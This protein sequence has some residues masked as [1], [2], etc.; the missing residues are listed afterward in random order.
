[1]VGVPYRQQ[2]IASQFDGIVIGSGIGGLSAAVLLARHGGK[3]LLVLARHYTA[4][5]F[6]P[7]FRRP[8]FEWDVGVH[9]IG[10]V[11]D[12]ESPVRRIFDHLSEGRLAW[13]PMPDGD[14][15]VILGGGCYDF[16]AGTDRFR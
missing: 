11:R 16:V 1:M 5:G 15:R 8:G 14:D 2:K 10:Q 3:R 12:P 6:T 7:V 4:G 13:A 9:Y